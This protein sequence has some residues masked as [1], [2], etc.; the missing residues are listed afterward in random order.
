MA[1]KSSHILAG[2]N[3]NLTRWIG[4]KQL[5]EPTVLLYRPRQRL[6]RG[7]WDRSVSFLN[8]SF[9]KVF[10]K[11]VFQS[12]FSIKNAWFLLWEAFR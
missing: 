11:L 5:R 6:S 9:F 12:I 10:F 3:I 1:P 4:A 2:D 8:Y 7:A